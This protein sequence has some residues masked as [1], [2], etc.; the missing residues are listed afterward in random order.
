ISI[1]ELGIW[2]TSTADDVRSGDEEEFAIGLD[3]PDDVAPGVYDVRIVISTDDMKRIKH[4]DV[5]I[6]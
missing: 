3:I 1:P 2:I 4:R 6:I 5:E